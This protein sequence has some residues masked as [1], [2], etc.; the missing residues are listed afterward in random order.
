MCKLLAN[1]NRYFTVAPIDKNTKGK[2]KESYHFPD[3]LVNV[4]YSEHTVQLVFSMI[5]G[6]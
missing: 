3:H 2:E 4:Q 6:I 1:K 5:L